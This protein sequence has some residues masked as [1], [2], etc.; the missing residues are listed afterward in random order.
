MTT[1][2]SGKITDPD[3]VV[4]QRNLD[5]FNQKAQEFRV[6]VFNPAD[7][8]TVGWTW[9]RYL[10]R[11]LTWI[12]DNK[13]DMYFMSGWEESRGARL[14]HELAIYLNLKM[15]YEQPTLITDTE[16]DLE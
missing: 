9:E 6:P 15:T 7:L 11:D 12:Y 16:P 2:L 10:I 4:M 5:R 1:Y 14:E 13:P 8:E 3:P